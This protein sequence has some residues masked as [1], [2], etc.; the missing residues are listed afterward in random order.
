M[1]SPE[2]RP[3][4]TPGLLVLLG[5]VGGIGL[6]GTNAFLPALPTMAEELDSTPSGVLLA[7]TGFTGGMAAGQVVA[8][9]LSDAVGRRRPVLI[10]ATGMTLAAAG[11]AVAPTVPWVILSCAV[12]GLFSAVGSVV[13]RATVSDLAEG[14]S[15]T[16]AYAWLSTLPGIGPVLGPVVGVAL[17]LAFGWRGIFFGLAVA[18]AACVLATLLVLPE[19][20]PPAQRA[21]GDVRRLAGDIATIFRSR[22]FLGSAT[23]IWLV[24]IAL[25]AYISASSF[26]MQ[27]TLGFS[28]IGY[29]VAFA[30]NGIA[31]ILAAAAAA[32]LSA[33]IGGRALAAV[34]IS[35]LSSGAACV[36]IAS[37]MTEPAAS[38]LLPG[39]L[40]IAASWSFTAGPCTAAALVDL[41]H[42]SGTALA[43]IGSLQF[44]FAGLIAPLQGVAGG[45][46]V[47]PF[48]I[49]ATSCA[50]LA[51][52]VWLVLRP[53]GRP[54]ASQSS[55]SSAR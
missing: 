33:R 24:F 34:G 15:L 3:Q 45:D 51:W 55:P 21:T 36:L 29:T 9:P 37:A 30:V 28:V 43:V 11:A 2:M 26:I 7:L 18:G 10:G 25:F 31:M 48:A 5:A 6:I 40:L 46:E 49:I 23:I 41:R 32:R 27:S 53:A 39:M 4:L 17:L 1:A 38:L 8:G 50:L 20:H 47:V 22:A 16:R 12:M 19:S 52:V 35:L 14:A 44:L 13:S 54:A 42:A